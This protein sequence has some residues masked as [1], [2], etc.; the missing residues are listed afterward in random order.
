MAVQAV[1]PAQGPA[2]VFPAPPS[3]AFTRGQ[4]P[5]YAATPHKNRATP[6][7][8][9]GLRHFVHPLTPAVTV[10]EERVFHPV[11]IRIT[12]PLSADSLLSEKTLNSQHAEQHRD[13][14]SLACLVDE[15]THN[16]LLFGL[17][18]R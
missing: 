10:L 17:W 7:Q 2:L 18:C 11:R 3:L 6:D 15:V 9:P 8:Q 4:P 12:C 13:A 16:G 14:K 5:H 1:L